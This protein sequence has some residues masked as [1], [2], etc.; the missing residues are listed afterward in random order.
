ML[1][2]ELF[3]FDTE[4]RDSSVSQMAKVGSLPR[5]YMGSGSQSCQ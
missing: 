4:I 2:K 1:L 3:E 5:D